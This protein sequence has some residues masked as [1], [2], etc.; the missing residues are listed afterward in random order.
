MRRIIRSIKLF[1][2]FSALFSHLNV[3][4]K[5]GFILLLLLFLLRFFLFFCSHTKLCANGGLTFISCDG[6]KA[7]SN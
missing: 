3:W 5:R 6:V 7:A 1:F 2:Y 4:A